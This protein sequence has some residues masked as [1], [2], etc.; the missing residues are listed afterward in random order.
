MIAEEQES[1]IRYAHFIM[2]VE[3]DDTPQTDALAI[4][5]LGSF[6]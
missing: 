6:C 5:A 2:Q 1:L 4:T 3:H